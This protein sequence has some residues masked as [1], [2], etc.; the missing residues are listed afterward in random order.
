M[1]SMAYRGAKGNIGAFSVRNWT[2]F[3]TMFPDPTRCHYLNV[4]KFGA[5]DLFSLDFYPGAKALE[6]SFLVTTTF[7]M[8]RNT[9]KAHYLGA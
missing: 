5:S 2:K 4:E 7:A 6:A 8:T 3:W 1:F 9:N